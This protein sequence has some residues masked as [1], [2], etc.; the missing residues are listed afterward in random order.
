MLARKSI[1]KII[2][3]ILCVLA[4]INLMTMIV[5]DIIEWKHLNGSGPLILIG[6]SYIV[7]HIRFKIRI[8]ELIQALFLGLAFILWGSEQLISSSRIITIMDDAVVAIFVLDLSYI[9]WQ[10]TNEP[11][12]KV[13]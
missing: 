13:N 11:V 6:M 8:K 2:S 1:C 10:H 5:T 7:L 9:I 3:K 4:L 12:K